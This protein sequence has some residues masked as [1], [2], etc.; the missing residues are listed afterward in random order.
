M[1]ILFCIFSYYYPAMVWNI[2]QMFRPLLVILSIS[3][4]IIKQR[5]KSYYFVL[6]HKISAY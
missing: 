1:N 2:F 5:M 3:F 4:M 6:Y